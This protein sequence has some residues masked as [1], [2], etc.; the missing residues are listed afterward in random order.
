V[1]KIGPNSYLEINSDSLMLKIRKS[2]W[3]HIF[4]LF[5]LPFL[6][7]L[8]HYLNKDADI[9]K[10]SDILF[11]A[12]IIFLSQL[13]I[14]LYNI[15]MQDKYEMDLKQCRVSR[16]KTLFGYVLKSSE[17]QWENG[18]TFSY[19]VEY[20]SERSITTVYLMAVNKKMNNRGRILTFYDLDTF[21][22]FRGAFETKYPNNLI[23]EW[24]N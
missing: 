4:G 19:E 12:G 20:D 6:L 3:S 16:N 17:Q 14:C 1:Q 10:N 11:Y 2:I 7:W 15:G 24:H 22:A 18:S 5:I 13:G 21:V 8:V 9:F 23:T